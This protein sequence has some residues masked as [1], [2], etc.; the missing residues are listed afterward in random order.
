V[1][2]DA[3]YLGDDPYEWIGLGVRYSGSEAARL[4]SV[5]TACSDQSLVYHDEYEP[6]HYAYIGYDSY[7]DH[8]QWIYDGTVIRIEPGDDVSFTGANYLAAGADA[9]MDS[10]NSQIGVFAHEKL[11]YFI[12]GYP[13]G[14]AFAPTDTNPLVVHEPPADRYFSSFGTSPFGQKS[15]VLYTNGSATCP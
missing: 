14:L 7:S 9:Y 3:I 2:Y 8:W 15:V 13:Y 12:N 5:C 6:H 1:V 4:V 11:V 10:Y